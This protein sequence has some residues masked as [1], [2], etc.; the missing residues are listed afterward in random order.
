MSAAVDG[1]CAAG[2]VGAFVEELIEV[3]FRARS[4]CES[5][6]VARA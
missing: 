1:L 2:S 3:D 4:L 5:R 6:R